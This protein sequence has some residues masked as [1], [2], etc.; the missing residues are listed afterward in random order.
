[1]KKRYSDKDIIVQEVHVKK[2]PFGEE[3]NK[4]KVEAVLTVLGESLF[5][6][7]YEFK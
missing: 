5:V 3:M 1:M 6:E 2:T 4:G 7:E